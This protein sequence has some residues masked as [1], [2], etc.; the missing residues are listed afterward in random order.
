MNELIKQ[1]LA[2]ARLF[3]KIRTNHAQEFGDTWRRQGK[4]K[5]RKGR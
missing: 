2:K 3:V 4:R 5:G 1:E